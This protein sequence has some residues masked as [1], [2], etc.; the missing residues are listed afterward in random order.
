M[1]RRQK[2]SL[3]V[4]AVI[5]AV[6]TYLAVRLIDLDLLWE[7][8]QDSNYWWLVP[9]FVLMAAAVIIRALRWQLLFLPDGRPPFRPTLRA[10]LIGQF[11]NCILPARTG[12]AA[13]VVVICRETSVP[14]PQ[15]A[16]TAVVERIYDVICLL[17]L[18]FAFLPF[19][20]EIDWLQRAAVVAAVV[21]GL[22][23]VGVV[24]LAVFGTRAVRVLLRPLAW[25]PRIRPEQVESVAERLTYGLAGLHRPG[26]AAAA[27]SLT[28]VSWL[29]FAASFWLLSIGFDLGI[30]YAGGMLVLIATSL[31][32]VIPALP[33]AIGTFEAAALVAL[34]AYGIDDSEALAYAVVLHALNVIPY[35]VLGYVL[36]HG[37]IRRG[38]TEP[39]ATAARKTA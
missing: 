26:M 3:A 21:G 28:I 14:W 36:V 25:L 7:A 9:A 2:I 13:R 34:S 6:F 11:G 15:A 23:L 24:V 20:P 1:S 16:G 12:E 29:I 10:L 39:A 32:L 4:G 35:I 27:F 37:H 33:G 17:I 22:A 5:S 8:L 38:L 30:D 18:L 31:V 19:F